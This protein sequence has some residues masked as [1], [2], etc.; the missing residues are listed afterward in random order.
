M[1]SLQVKNEEALVVSGVVPTDNLSH[2]YLHLLS[3]AFKFREAIDFTYSKGVYSSDYNFRKGD[4]VTISGAT[5]PAHN[6]DYTITKA[7][8]KK[9]YIDLTYVDGDMH[10]YRTFQATQMRSDRK[11]SSFHVGT[12]E[13]PRYEMIYDDNNIV[14]TAFKTYPQPYKV[15]IDYVMGPDIDIDVTNQ[16]TDLTTY[17]SQKFLYRLIDECVATFAEQTKD[18]TTLQIANKAIIDNP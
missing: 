9:F 18:V 8:N 10:L 1:F 11:K 17:F 16:A 2:T 7:R 3:M 4:V 5:N 14:P 6:G 12:T 13:S 15:V